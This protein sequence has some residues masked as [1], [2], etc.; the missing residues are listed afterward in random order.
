[1]SDDSHAFLKATAWYAD[2]PPSLHN[3]HFDLPLG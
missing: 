1:M 3:T 2:K